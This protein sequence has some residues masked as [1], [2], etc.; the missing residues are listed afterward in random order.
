MSGSTWVA[1][2]GTDPDTFGATCWVS[3]V[4]AYVGP[5]PVPELDP[6]VVLPVDASKVTY[7]IVPPN[8]DGDDGH[9]AGSGAYAYTI[10]DHFRQEYLPDEL[11]VY[12][13]PSALDSGAHLF[14][15]WFPFGSGLAPADLP[16]MVISPFDLAPAGWVAGGLL[17]ATPPDDPETGTDGGSPAD[18]EPVSW[19]LHDTDG[20]LIGTLANVKDG[21]WQHELSAPGALSCKVAADDALF[22]SLTPKRII[23]AWWRG[24]CRMAA[25]IDGS[26]VDLAVDGRRWREFNQL[27]GVLNVLAD[28]IVCPDAELVDATGSQ[29]WFGYMSAAGAWYDASDWVSPIATAWAS[30]TG[31][32]ANRPEGL[33]FPNPSWIAVNGPDVDES[34]GAV[35]YFRKSFTLSSTINYQILAT[36]DNTLTLWLDGQQ[37]VQSEDLGLNWQHLAQVTG[38]IGAGTH[39]LAAKV[40]NKPPRPRWTYSANPMGL[41]LT[42][43]RVHTNG[44]VYEET[45]VV[46]SNASWKASDAAVGFRRGDV[47]ATIFDEA[48]A[49]GVPAFTTLSRGFTHTLDSNGD[50]WADAPGEYALDVQSTVLDGVTA[51]SEKDID[52][53]VDFDTLTLQVFN[54]KGTDLSGSV[55][56]KAYTPSTP[57]G[58]ATALR[59]ER[60][61]PKFNTALV[62]K[63]DGT[64]AWVE[65]SASVADFGRIETG[66]ELG[67]TSETSTAEDVAAAVFLESAHTAYTFTVEISTLTGPQPYVNF[68][69]G[70]SIT[71]IDDEGASRK[72][73]VMAIT[74]AFDQKLERWVPTL[75]V[76]VDR[77]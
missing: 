72:A 71:L 50:A 40:A 44:D 33:D 74:V 63:A 5:I 3:D 60:V 13:D 4:G 54:R 29:R 43:Q 75:E 38:T 57:D 34:D 41:I 12:G 77:S 56:I 55:T 45:P 69:V 21:N 49:R 22:S 25:R 70:D 19:T 32:R 17:G 14:V 30:E 15:M 27:P 39:L 42:L 10:T 53:D 1:L 37:L 48:R 8:P 23:K 26:A 9:V 35:Q 2:D 24:G 11:D 67:S 65:D 7:L 18:L 46:N 62:R 31:V 6:A 36:G 59:V 47:I 58:S 61:E 64:F 52:V 76:T 20:S 16:V 66:L 73:R 28:G 51:L 68:N